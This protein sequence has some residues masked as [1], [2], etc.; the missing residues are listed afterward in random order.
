M[1]SLQ[2][3][4]ILHCK[5]VGTVQN[6]YNLKQFCIVTIIVNMWELYK[7]FSMLKKHCKNYRKILGII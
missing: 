3:Y 6:V 7:M 5:L 2:F 4:T 1:K